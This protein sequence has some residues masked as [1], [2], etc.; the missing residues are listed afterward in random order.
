MTYL[1]FP[2]PREKYDERKPTTAKWAMYTLYNTKFKT[3]SYVCVYI[4]VVGTLRSCDDD[5]DN[6]DIG[7]FASKVRPSFS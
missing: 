7:D 6:D 5:D 1:D 4:L 3:I 2:G